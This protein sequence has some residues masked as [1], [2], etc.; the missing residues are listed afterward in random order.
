[1]AKHQAYLQCHSCYVLAGPKNPDETTIL[2]RLKS[3]LHDGVSIFNHKLHSRNKNCSGLLKHP[4]TDRRFSFHFLYL[5]LATHLFGCCLSLYNKDLSSIRLSKLLVN[6]LEQ[7]YAGLWTP[8]CS[9]N[10][11][12][13]VR[14][15]SIER[16][17]FMLETLL[18]WY[19]KK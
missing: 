19:L 13:H 6:S 15:A 11:N 1:M 10:F 4:L 16:R 17:G 9:E 18:T 7:M 8:G 2:K 3:R 5:S 12:W 14:S